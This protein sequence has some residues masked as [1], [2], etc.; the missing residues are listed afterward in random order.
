[1]NPVQTD[2]TQALGEPERASSGHSFTTL[3]YGGSIT[4][5]FGGAIVNGPGA[6][7]EIVE[8]T[9]GYP[10]YCS[11]YPEYA[12][13]YVS[14][15][16]DNWFFAKTVCKYDGFVDISDAGDLDYVN[17]VKI[18]NNDELSTTPDAF[19]VD[20]VVAIHI[21][22]DEEPAPAPFTSVEASATL[23]TYPNPTQGPSNVVFK[24]AETGKV[25]L[26]VYDMSG[27]SVATLFDAEAQ[28]DK[29][30]TL[31]FNGST[32]PNGVYVYRLTTNNE[33]IIEKFMIAR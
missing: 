8:T 11:A 4:L 2:P 32:L 15:D 29:E 1:M 30:Y 5:G 22:I 9:Y 3:G 14:Q 31:D 20:G 16:G 12:D 21:C 26:E 10:A 25:L 19:D 18:V 13:I 6:D 24:T 33:T 17:Y 7:I 27:R 23:T 28:Q